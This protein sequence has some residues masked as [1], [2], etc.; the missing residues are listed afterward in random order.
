MEKKTQLEKILNERCCCGLCCCK[1]R[2]WYIGLTY[3]LIVLDIVN[4]TAGLFQIINIFFFESGI[5][6]KAYAGYM[7]MHAPM[8]FTL[9]VKLYY[10]VRWVCKRHKRSAL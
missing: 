10:G 6:Y 1:R 3:L 7:I 9:L 4:L 5:E 8:S 2:C